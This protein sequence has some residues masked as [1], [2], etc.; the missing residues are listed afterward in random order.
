M[1]SVNCFG[2][3]RNEFQKIKD[4]FSLVALKNEV[5]IWIE[6]WVKLK[7]DSIKAQM[8]YFEIDEKSGYHLN[9]VAPLLIELGKKVN[10][11][12]SFLC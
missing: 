9:L 8:E 3:K 12:Y 5:I 10:Y 1:S 2:G 7:L 6:I 11:R 4:K